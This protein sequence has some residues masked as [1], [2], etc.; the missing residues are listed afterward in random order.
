MDRE[1]DLGK[2]GEMEFTFCTLPAR[3]ELKSK[4]A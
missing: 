4:L 3:S 2:A 1:R